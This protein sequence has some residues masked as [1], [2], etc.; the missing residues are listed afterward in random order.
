MGQ[1]GGGPLSSLGRMGSSMSSSSITS[2]GG[3]LVHFRYLPFSWAHFQLQGFFCALAAWHTDKRQPPVDDGSGYCPNRMAIGKFLAIRSRNID[4]TIR[5]T[6]LHAQLLPEAFGRRTSA[7]ARGDEQCDVR[8]RISVRGRTKASSSMTRWI[9]TPPEKAVQGARL[10]VGLRREIFGAMRSRSNGWT[11]VKCMLRPG[12]CLDFLVLLE[13]SLASL[14]PRSLL[15][16]R[17]ADDRRSTGGVA[18]RIPRRRNDIP[19]RIGII[20]WLQPWHS[21]SGVASVLLERILRVRPG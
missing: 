20:W 7:T 2:P 5:K 13:A 15:V 21:A 12:A 4:F 16:C 18:G 19:G 3:A 9:L 6:V 10:A 1:S 14:R 8:H 11:D 17:A